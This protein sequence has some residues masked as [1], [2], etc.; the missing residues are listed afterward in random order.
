M[1]IRRKI[2]M[3]I[4]IVIIFGGMSLVMMYGVKCGTDM[5]K[6]DNKAI[7][8]VQTHGSN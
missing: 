5:I 8:E 3:L 4:G 6:A 2:N 1:S 7:M